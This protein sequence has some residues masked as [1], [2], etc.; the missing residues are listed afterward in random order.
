MLY[1]VKAAS[2][3]EACEKVW[4]MNE[5]STHYGRVAIESGKK[6]LIEVASP[7]E[8][9]SGYYPVSIWMGRFFIW[10]T[11]VGELYWKNEVGATPGGPGHPVITLL[12]G[13]IISGW[14]AADD[15]HKSFFPWMK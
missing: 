8:M 6:S 13:K 15:F 1:A 11:P 4:E 7:K 14:K 12:N 5:V 10:E 2:L 9:L 3:K